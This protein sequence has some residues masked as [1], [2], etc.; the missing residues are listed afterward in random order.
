MSEMPGPS[1]PGGILR[2]KI[3]LKSGTVVP[4]FHTFKMT[5]PPYSEI[6]G[7]HDLLTSYGLGPIEAIFAGSRRVKEPL[8]T[9]LPHIIGKFNFDHTREAS[10]LQA[11]IAKPPIHKEITNLNS[12]SMQGFKL[13]AGPVDERYKDYFE[14]RKDGAVMLYSEKMNVV[15]P[16]PSYD[17]YGIDGDETEKP[18]PRKHKKKKKDKKRKKDR[19]GVAE[20]SERKKKKEEAKGTPMEF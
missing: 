20:P 8:S 11:L 10:S 6:Q 1:G 9:F 15:R 13:T 19:E 7:N 4:P 2:T 18:F 16:K 12:S 5:L 14:R 17:I 3:S